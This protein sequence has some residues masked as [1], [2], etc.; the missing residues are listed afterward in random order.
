[1][2]EGFLRSTLAKESRAYGFTIAFWGSGALLIKAHD[3]PTL[4]EA[5]SYGAGAIFGFGL[6]ALWAYKRTLGAAEYEEN[7]LLVFSMMHYIGALLPVCATYYIAQLPSPQAFLL[8]GAVV[9]VGYNFGMLAEEVLS[10][11][12][13]KL[14]KKL[15]GS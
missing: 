14:E 3:L 1:M 4:L 10:E 11:E 6:L 13:V 15:I 2:K 8:A 9:S 12:A 7:N 5:L